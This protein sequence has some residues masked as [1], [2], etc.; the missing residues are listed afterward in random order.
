MNARISLIALI[1]FVSCISAQAVDYAVDPAFNPTFL[2]PDFNVDTSIGDVVVQADGKVLIGG[3]FS[4]VNDETVYYLARLNPDGTRDITFNSAI[5][6][7]SGFL[8]YVRYIT[9]LPGGKLLVTGRFKIGNE[10][11]T[12]VK[13]NSDGSIDSSMSTYAFVNDKIVPLP[14]GKFLMCGGRLV[15]D[16]S[17]W[18]AHRLNADGSVDPD[19][20]ITFAEGTCSDLQLQP[21]GKFLMAATFR[22][23][24]NFYFE[25]VQ[26]FNADGSRDTTFNL[27]TS[28]AYGAI[29]AL[30][31]D[32]KVLVTYGEGSA[33]YTKRFNTDGSVDQTIPYCLSQAFL[34]LA[35][36]RV[37]MNGCRKWATGLTYQFA[38]TLPDGKIEP[39]LDWIN[40]NGNVGGFRQAEDGKFYAFGSFTSVNGATRAK[41]VRLMP[42][43]VPIKAKFDFD[44]DGKSD[45]AVFRTSD[46]YWYLYQSSLGPRYVQWG[47]ST[48]KPM[49]ADYDTDEKTDIGMYR[50]TD[51]VWHSSSSEWGYTWLT[52]GVRGKPLVGDFD[53]DKKQ[54]W[55]I[56]KVQNNVVSWLITSNSQR[57]FGFATDEIADERESD[58]PVVGDFDGDAREEIGYFRDGVWFTRDYGSGA[59]TQSFQWGSAGDIP[60]PADYDGDGQADYA[61]FRPSTGVWWINQSS[62]GVFVA[63]FGLD[64]D[65]PVPADYDG[66]GKVDLAIF[67]N[68]QWWQY[69]SSTGVHVDSWG[70]AGDIPIPAQTQ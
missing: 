34:P 65:I 38:N 55:V 43:T 27:A 26:R 32:G 53:G 1:L 46:R 35:G 10:Y 56:R 18:L 70:I 59:Q 20:R 37:L 36:G 68:G 4:K 33:T 57:G 67:R 7:S 28:S 9:P 24:N 66:D 45:L 31:P 2:F 61:V 69:R 60:V 19:F 14:D 63:R 52:L 16:E 47:L 54:D 64:G 51:A 58:I 25:P 17:Y 30:L 62:A 12:Y 29:F 21:D 44:G 6:P 22:T 50:D 11:S 48:D 5:V 8:N 49:A 42:Y 23:S 39:S 41:I 15:N 3:T 13:L 40:F